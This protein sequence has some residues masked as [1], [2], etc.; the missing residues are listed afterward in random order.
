MHDLRRKGGVSLAQYRLLADCVVGHAHIL[1]GTTVSMP[2][3]WVPH[4]NCEPLDAAA[5]NAFYAAG[6]QTAG[7]IRQ[8]WS[9][10]PVGPP[11]TYW[12]ATSL[13][14]V[15]GA[16]GLTSWQ[17]VGLGSNLPAIVT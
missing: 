13:P 11:A 4:G 2:D 9:G 14:A 10:I 16:S 12:R 1:A 5:L 8:T 15:P 7:L 17:L 3:D 6:P